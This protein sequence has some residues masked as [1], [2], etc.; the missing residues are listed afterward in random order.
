VVDSPRKSQ[1]TLLASGA[2]LLLGMFYVL[3]RELMRGAPGGGGRRTTAPRQTP[4]AGPA[5]VAMPSMA[6]TRLSD[7]ATLAT[8]IAKLPRGAGMGAG[9]ILVTGENDAQN[10]LDAATALAQHLATPSTPVVLIDLASATG[11]DRYGLKDLVQGTVSFEAVVH[12]SENGR[13]HRITAGKAASSE[14]LRANGSNVELVFSALDA[15][16]THVIVAAPRTVAKDML[17][18]LDGNFS[19]GVV[20][21]DPSRSTSAPIEDGFLGYDVSGLSVVWW[22]TDRALGKRP[23]GR[24]AQSRL[25]PA[26]A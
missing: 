15:I 17:E 7:G 26:A 6:T 24:V 9:R 11:A 2:A 1:L 10:P 12:P 20:A 21:A 23:A 13:W 22:D 8:H 3:S 25:S 19:V 4:K 14:R 18:A 16:Y 5:L